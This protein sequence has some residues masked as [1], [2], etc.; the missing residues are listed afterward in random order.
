MIVDVQDLRKH[1]GAFE[2]VKGISFQVR[3]GELF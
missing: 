2:A 1:Y 3:K